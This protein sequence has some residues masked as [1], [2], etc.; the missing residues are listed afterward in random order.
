MSGRAREH[1]RSNVIGYVA[2]FI[3]LAGGAYALPGRNSV[4][5]GDIRNNQVRSVDIRNEQ[6]RTADIR[7]NNV[8]GRDLRTGAVGTEDIGDNAISGVDV[9]PDS[10]SGTDIVEGS[11]QGVDAETLAGREVCD[12]NGRL[13]VDNGPNGLEQA[14]VCAVGPFE[15]GLVCEALS[16][17]DSVDGDIVVTTAADETAVARPGTSTELDAGDDWPLLTAADTT[18][19]NGAV[20]S[21]P[22]TFSVWTL[23][24]HHLT[25][26][27]AMR[28]ESR[29][30]NTRTCDFAVFA[31][32]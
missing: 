30:D 32:G 28:L 5:S 21:P 7:N 31:T 15:I 16:G 10:L 25:G 18:E 4:G 22:G 1:L 19:G 23:G 6:I 12:Y 27:T 17:G 14:T 20:V 11:L 8:L 29:A 3:A 24:G 13:T 9:A 2:L 26:H